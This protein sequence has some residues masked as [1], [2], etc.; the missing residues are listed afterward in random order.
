MPPF[1]LEA[2]SCALEAPGPPAILWGCK[3]GIPR[4]VLCGG[5]LERGCNFSMAKSTGG[6]CP[7]STFRFE[8]P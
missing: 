8:S 7:G 6:I 4:W 3:T 1:G 5:P 2:R